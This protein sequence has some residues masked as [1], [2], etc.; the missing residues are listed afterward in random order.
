M[1]VINLA[2]SRGA[3]NRTEADAAAAIW[4]LK[5]L[6]P[7]SPNAWLKETVDG[8]PYAAVALSIWM[9]HPNLRVAT[10]KLAAYLTPKWPTSK[11]ESLLAKAI[12]NAVCKV[13]AA[14]SRGESFEGRVVGVYLFWLA[15]CV[16]DVARVAV[17]GVAKNGEVMRWQYFSEPLHDWA[18][19]HGMTQLEAVLADETPTEEEIAGLRTH[20]VARITDNP[21]DAGY[22]EMHA[23]RG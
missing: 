2:H 7:A 21:V 15:N 13:E 8:K 16:A 10:E 19:R 5:D 14:V 11:G 12:E 3:R 22:L 9:H 23:P 17:F 1:T 6:I 4:P 18:K 20:L